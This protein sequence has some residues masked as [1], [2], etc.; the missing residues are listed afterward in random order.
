MT[1]KISV[2]AESV[3]IP[4]QSSPE[5][6]HYFFAYSIQIK[7][8]GSVPAKLMSRHWIITD[9]NSQVSEVKGDG[10]VGEQ[11]RLEPGETFEYSSA[12]AIKTPRGSMEGS[13]QLV[14]DDGEEFE[15]EIP[16]FDLDAH[17]ALH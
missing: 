16:K 13:Y 2:L 1:Y 3:F 8:V 11:P 17:R 15:A 10:V 12:A 5:Q 4:E 14:A 6:Q 9:G 7:N